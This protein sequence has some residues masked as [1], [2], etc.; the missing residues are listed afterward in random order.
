[1]C[2][3]KEQ[4]QNFKK[5]IDGEKL[6]MENSTI[7]EIKGQEKV[8]LKKTLGK[9]L[10]LNNVLYI[11]EI[12]KNLIF[13]SLLSNHGFRIC[14]EYDIIILS[15][16]EIFI[17]KRNITVFFRLVVMA[18]RFKINKGESFSKYILESSIL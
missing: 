13:G 15:K 6:F 11:S 16:N 4:F 1:M 3:N 5:V 2:Y 17:G 10:T 14:F 8:V 18:I 7:L 12:H 9:K